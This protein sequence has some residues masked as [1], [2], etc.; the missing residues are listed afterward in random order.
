V[1]KKE[2]KVNKSLPFAKVNKSLPFVNAKKG[3][4]F[5][6]EGKPT[7]IQLNVFYPAEIKRLNQQV[8]TLTSSRET[9]LVQIEI[10]L[11]ELMSQKQVIEDLKG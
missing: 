1:F 2:R 5:T 10:Q 4:P 9:M 11:S 3:L 6:N 8:K 7:N